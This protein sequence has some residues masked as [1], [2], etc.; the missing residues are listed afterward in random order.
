MDLE[1]R[2]S[3]ASWKPELPAERL[4]LA[5]FPAVLFDRLLRL[6]RLLLFAEPHPQTRPPLLVKMPSKLQPRRP[7]NR[8][9]PSSNLQVRRRALLRLPAAQA[10][11]GTAVPLPCGTW[12]HRPSDP[13]IYKLPMPRRLHPLP[14][15]PPKHRFH[16]AF[17]RP[18]LT[19]QLVL[20]LLRLVNPTNNRRPR[21]LVSKAR[22]W[23]NNVSERPNAGK[24]HRL[25]LHLAQSRRR[26]SDRRLL[27]SLRDGERLAARPLPRLNRRARSG[28]GQEMLCQD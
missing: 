2:A 21:S 1:T 3:P 25:Q 27:M 4:Q 15:L 7:N 19:R 12:Q 5:L 17:N 10:W 20:H 14:Q 8:P 22:A 18:R 9:R 23:S 13:T 16:Q 11:R 28:R 6:A 24:P 26:L